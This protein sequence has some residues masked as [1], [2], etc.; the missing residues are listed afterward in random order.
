M[1][2]ASGK[3]VLA[4]KTHQRAAQSHGGAFSRDHVHKLLVTGPPG[5]NAPGP[6]FAPPAAAVQAIPVA[7]AAFFATRLS[8]DPVFRS[9]LFAD[10]LAFDKDPDFFRFFMC[11]SLCRDCAAMLGGA[12][13]RHRLSVLS[14]HHVDR[15]HDFLRRSVMDHVSCSG[16]TPQRAVRNVPVQMGR[17]LAFDKP[18]VR[19]CNN[20][21]RHLQK[22]IP[23]PWCA[24]GI[25]QPEFSSAGSDL[26][27][28]R[29][30]P[31]ESL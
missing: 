2:N 30:S 18:I 28:S 11:S 13:R 7:A 10:F 6:L 17:L 4:A 3:T 27:Q 20:C 1:T 12:C 31:L 5:C 29:P 14:C 26:R 25:D 23:F 9:A 22:P 19:T 8:F 15:G 16:N 24:D 21:D